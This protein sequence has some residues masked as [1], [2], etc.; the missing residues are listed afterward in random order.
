MVCACICF[1]IIVQD[2]H[3]SSL[4]IRDRV[5]PPT[6]PGAVTPTGLP[7]FA[8]LSLHADSPGSLPLEREKFPAEWKRTQKMA[9]VNW[10]NRHLKAANMRISDLETDLSDGLSLPALVEV[11][12]GKKIPRYNRTP[13]VRVQKQENVAICLEFLQ[14]DQGIKL[15][16]IGRQSTIRFH[17]F[18]SWVFIYVES[19][20]T[21]MC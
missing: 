5:K 2:I 19:A 3:E 16:N 7:G 11:L 1:V 10:A 6:I 18:Y 9:F 4:A 21:F 12:S 8:P 15:I 20:R 17:V 13:A 14:K